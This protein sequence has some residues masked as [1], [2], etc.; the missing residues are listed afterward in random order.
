MKK[1][2]SAILAATTLLSSVAF[3]ADTDI[4]ISSV[5]VKDGVVTV[6]VKNLL[7]TET[8]IMMTAIKEKDKNN[9][10]EDDRTYAMRQVEAKADATID[11][12]FVIPDERAGIR[13]SGT[14][15]ITVKNSQG[16]K[17]EYPLI[18]ADS[19]AIE[20]SCSDLGRAQNAGPTESLRL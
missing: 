15:A 10:S 1:I 19:K 12:K 14:Y 2:F 13:G 8:E 16:D 18:Y 17:A 9:Y 5:S 3:A 7:K 4:S 20:D 11:L 6:T